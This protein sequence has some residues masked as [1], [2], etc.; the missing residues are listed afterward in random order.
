M[1]QLVT[2]VNAAQERWD[3]LGFIAASADEVGRDFGFGRVLGDD[4]WLLRGDL[5]ADLILAIGR[6]PIRAQVMARYLAM[7]ARFTYPNLVHPTA[8]VDRERVELGQGNAITAGCIFTT[9]IYVGDFNL[10][11]LQTTV[12]HDARI[13]SFNVVNPSVNISGGVTIGDRVLVGTG[14]QILEG[15]S[16]GSGAQVGAGAVV[17]RDVELDVTVVG[18]PARPLAN[19]GG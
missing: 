11:N 13:G 18:I 14:A 15:L 6:P 3:L 9:H 7:G 2:H 12:G 8:I 17:T 19:R 5:E 1:A 16:V 10:F 4:D